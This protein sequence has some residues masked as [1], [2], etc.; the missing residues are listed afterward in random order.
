MERRR[1]R[2]AEVPSALDT[3]L[4]GALAAFEFS[5]A[6]SR[7]LL[8]LLVRPGPVPLSAISRDAGIPRSTAHSSLRALA[9]RGLIFCEGR[10]PARYRAGFTSRHPRLGPSRIGSTGCRRSR[11]DQCGARRLTHRSHVLL[12]GT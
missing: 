1:V 2:N 9:K 12:S 6:E 10:Y 4:L 7:A 8:A 11:N 3:S 5:Q